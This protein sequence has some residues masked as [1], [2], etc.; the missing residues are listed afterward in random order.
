M[1][2]A[3]HCDPNSGFGCQG[4]CHQAYAENRWR[5]RRN[6]HNLIDTERQRQD[7]IWGW[8][9]N[10]LASGSLTYKLAILAEEFGEIANAILLHDADNMRTELV[11]VAAVCV[12]WLES[13]YEQGNT[14]AI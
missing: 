6:I 7:A 2:H 3:P 5:I 13:E 1:N 9:D 12:A 4:E 10:G 14:V 11:Q 8:P